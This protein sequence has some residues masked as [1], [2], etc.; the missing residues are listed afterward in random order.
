MWLCGWGTGN[1]R[2]REGGTDR[3]GELVWRVVVWGHRRVGVQRIGAQV[4]EVVAGPWD[5]RRVDDDEVAHVGSAHTSR[6]HTV[7]VQSPCTC[8]QA[9]SRPTH[10]LYACMDPFATHCQPLPRLA[11]CDV[12]ALHHARRTAR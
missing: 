3:G 10:S 11:T 1:A 7:K 6:G 12:T 9:L 2:T 8:H 4:G 5:R